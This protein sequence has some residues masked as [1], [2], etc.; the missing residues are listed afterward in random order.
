MTEEPRGVGWVIFDA[1]RRLTIFGLG[2]WII[3]SAL[4]DPESDNTISMLV[5]GMVMVGVLPIE[6]IFLP[7]ITNRRRVN[8]A[9]A[10][11][12]PTRGP[13]TDSATPGPTA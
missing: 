2:T 7:W 10:V 5:I 12:S 9:Q 1:V 11:G 13:G 8:G 6:N 3:V 4:N